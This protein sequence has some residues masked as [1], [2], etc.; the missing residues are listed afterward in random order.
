[1]CDEDGP[2]LSCPLFRCVMDRHESG[3]GIVIVEPVISQVKR[4]AC[5]VMGLDGCYFT[6]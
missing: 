4:I 2:D 3:N 1:M 6:W 5:L